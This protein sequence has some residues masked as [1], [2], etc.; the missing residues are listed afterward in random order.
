MSLNVEVTEALAAGGKESSVKCP[1]IMTRPRPSTKSHQPL[2]APT[3]DV[4]APGK[5]LQG[6]RHDRAPFQPRRGK[7]T[8]PPRGILGAAAPRVRQINL[9]CAF[10]H[11]DLRGGP[12]PRHALAEYGEKAPSFCFL[13][14]RWLLESTFLAQRG[15][16]SMT[17]RT[18]SIA[19]QKQQSPYGWMSS[20]P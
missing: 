11:H 2:R 5:R 10:S 3:G 6:R 1:R 18:C 14:P 19:S 15:L 12:L 7:P 13:R 4:T 17:S 8:T 9:L 20:N 16:S